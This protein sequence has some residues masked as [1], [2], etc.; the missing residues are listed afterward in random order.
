MN[1]LK[2]ALPVMIALAF[3]SAHAVTPPTGVAQTGSLGKNLGNTTVFSFTES[4]MGASSTVHGSYWSGGV[5]TSGASGTVNGNFTSVGAATIGDHAKITGNIKSGGVLT[6]GDTGNVSGYALSG[7][8]ATV[9]ANGQIAGDLRA[10]GVIT[11]GANAIINGAVTGPSMPVI[12]ASAT[13][14]S[15]RVANSAEA[16]NSSALTDSL[17]AQ[18]V[19][20]GKLIADA[21][22][23]LAQM[24]TSTSLIAAQTTDRTF[25]A[26]VYEAASWTTTAGITITLDAEHKDN[27]SF[28][29]NFSDIFSTGAGTKIKLINAG[30]NDSVIW[31]SYGAGGYAQLG[32]ST[33]LIGTILATTYIEVGASSH[34]TGVDNACGGVYSAT[35]YVH[36]GA[37]AVIGGTGCNFG[38]TAAVTPDST[39]GAVPEPGTYAMLMA[40]L[41]AVGF[42]ARRRRASI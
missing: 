9:G 32:A 21:Q 6:V 29:F 25:Y 39:V 3:A 35:S 15:A 7:G 33:D 40:G 23:A 36:G 16:V 5:I 11:V 28:I 31:N 19:A 34:V 26:G 42:V 24:Q 30:A 20:G 37:S 8:A 14:G 27:A 10:G 12:S 2:L 4:T 13:V 1:F 38:A 41:G 18:N 22:S 17:K